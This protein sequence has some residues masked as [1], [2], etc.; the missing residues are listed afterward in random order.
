MESQPIK[1]VKVRPELLSGG[2]FRQWTNQL[3]ETA[4]LRKYILQPAHQDLLPW[5]FFPFLLN[6]RI[7]KVVFFIQL[8]YRGEKNYVF[9]EILLLCIAILLLYNVFIE[10]PGNHII[11]PHLHILLLL[12][13]IQPLLNIV[14]GMTLTSHTLDSNS[15]YRDSPADQIE[16]MLRGFL[17]NQ[18]A[19]VQ[20]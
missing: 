5:N 3:H 14:R 16:R 7:E 2:R 6:L 15:G 11:K 20:S 8:L 18:Q 19:E 13:V 4:L 1:M 17:T 9:K 12:R 10:R